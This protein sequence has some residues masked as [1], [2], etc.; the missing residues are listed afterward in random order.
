MSRLQSR[1]DGVFSLH[2]IAGSDSDSD[3]SDN[4]DGDD[5]DRAADSNLD[6]LFGN[7]DAAAAAQKDDPLD[8]LFGDD[9]AAAH[10]DVDDSIGDT[11]ED[12][13]DLS[14]DIDESIK[15]KV[16][17]SSP[18]TVVLPPVAAKD[19]VKKKSEDRSG[20]RGIETASNRRNQ[21]SQESRRKER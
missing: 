9:D 18:L 14:G 5:A 17:S 13:G 8:N 2:D 15:E 21:T 19:V 3:D 6:D 1:K 12:V 20:E 4:H 11:N 10:E 7:D 16:V